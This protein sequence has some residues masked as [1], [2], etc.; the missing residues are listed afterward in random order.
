MIS[1]SA[2]FPVRSTA[3]GAT[4]FRCVAAAR[5]R[6]APL[7]GALAAATL[8]SVFGCRAPDGR[9]RRGGASIADRPSPVT[10]IAAAAPSLHPKLRIE[11]TAG[12][13]DAEL[14]ADKAPLTVMNFLDYVEA[15]FYNGTVFH[16]ITKDSM[17]QGGAY[18]RD[19]DRKRIGLR[20]PIDSEAGRGLVNDRWSIGMVRRPRMP[21]SAQA[22]FYVNIATNPMLDAAD[23]GRGYAVFGHV[24][25]G[26]SAIRRIHDAP[27]AAHPEYAAGRSAVVPVDPVEIRGIEVLVPL[28]RTAAEARASEWH[29][30]VEEQ[31]AELVAR[32][33]RET[34]NTAVRTESGLIYVDR[35]VGDGGVPVPGDSVEVY[36]RGTFL[37]GYEFES[38]TDRSVT[39]PLDSLVAGW[40]EGLRSMQEG[41][42]RVMILPPDLAYGSGGIPGR[43]PAY[44]TLVFEVELLQIP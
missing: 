16:R 7:A 22:E 10:T 5:A 18:T 13:F 29:R 43:I 27:V 23:D 39:L 9:E 25:D 12:T 30:P 41:G 26:F 1:A 15:G 2:C 14:N 44:A 11:T 3:L 31:V 35:T 36:Y 4:G 42:K 28:D 19:L 37:D 32:L 8:L 21:N 38:S 34:A 17:I 20:P 6:R 24:V 40:Q 33:E